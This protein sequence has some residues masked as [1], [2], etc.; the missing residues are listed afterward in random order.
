M[1]VLTGH[2]MDDHWDDKEGRAVGEAV[3]VSGTACLSND[4]VNFVSAACMMGL[5][6]TCGVWLGVGALPV[7]G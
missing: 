3:V 1:Q 6:A 4:G 2:D 5:G 7:H